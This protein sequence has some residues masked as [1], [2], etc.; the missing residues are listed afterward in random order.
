MIVIV[1]VKKEAEDAPRPHLSSFL[2]FNNELSYA[3]GFAAAWLTR[4]GANEIGVADN[5]RIP[6]TFDVSHFTVIQVDNSE[7][8]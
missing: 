7:F 6:T 2:G 5:R 3:W 8:V 1:H 4:L